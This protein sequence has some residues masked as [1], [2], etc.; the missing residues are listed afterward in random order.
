MNPIFGRCFELPAKLPIDHTLSIV[1]MDWDRGTG[2]YRSGVFVE[3]T[4]SVRNDPF[5][6]LSRAVLTTSFG[7]QCRLI[8]H[9][10]EGFSQRLRAQERA[11]HIKA[12]ACNKP[13]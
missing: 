3:Y 6:K 10:Y 7:G 8:L 13:L 5:R 4:Y 2:D 1:V 9:K 11:L 12:A